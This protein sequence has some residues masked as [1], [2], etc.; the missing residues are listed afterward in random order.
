MGKNAATAHQFMTKNLSHRRVS[1]REQALYGSLDLLDG[2]HILMDVVSES[3]VLYPVRML[4]KGHVTYF[5][6]TLAK[7]MGLIAGDHP[8]IMN[9][10]LEKKLIETFSLR[11]VNEYDQSHNLKV[12]K[13]LLKPKKYMATRYL[14]LQHP[15]KTGRTSGDGRCIWNGQITHNGVVWDV[16][17]RG[18]GV[19]CL[20]PGV[21]EAG[22]PLRS[23]ST[24]FG[25]GCGLAEVDELYG[26][27]LMAES[28]HNNGIGTERV[29]CIIDLGKGLGIGVRAAP[30]LLRPAHLFLYL[31]QNRYKELKA[32]TDYHIQR[33]KTNKRWQKMKVVHINPYDQLLHKVCD[34]FA[35]FTARLDRDYIFAW[36]DWDGDNVLIDAGIID[37]GS[38]RQ[39][40]LRHDQYRYDD[41]DRFSTNLN[42]QK[43]R[44]RT[45][46][47]VFAQ[48]VDYL[49]TGRKKTLQNF[50]HHPVLK[51]FDR[52]LYDYILERFLFNLGYSS[53]IYIKLLEDHRLKVENLFRSY[54]TL[55]RVKTHKKTARVADGVNRPAILNMR[56]ANRFCAEE[57]VRVWPDLY[58]STVPA[59]EMFRS[60]LAQN[61]SKVDHRPGLKVI[62]EL[63]HFQKLYK[64][65]L[66]AACAYG[67]PDTI[68]RDL[69]CQAR[70]RNR[71]DRVTGNA[72]I[73]VVDAIMTAKKQGL[74]KEELQWCID[75]FI[76]W[77]SIT[78]DTPDIISPLTNSDRQFSAQSQRL[79]EKIFNIV[80]QFSEDI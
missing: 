22:R 61:V 37:Y 47:Q 41:V 12:P 52:R 58:G 36:L 13:K 60:V 32:V 73:Y 71:T 8:H 76:K 44:A 19:T 62:R 42:E 49:K 69:L 6:Y 27:A 16:S 15:D 17:S 3:C 7:E 1:D 21:V 23:G 75:Q 51:E 68:V 9:K 72:L 45:T 77:Q 74:K 33:Q 65:L 40:G 64:K 43:Q 24:D 2:S 14:Q 50:T 28:F 80:E 29:L 70:Y 30:N 5:N 66:E 35:R 63:N 57:I 31:K 53:D 67:D 55:E 4:Q 59:E 54:S 38:I 34:D 79:C 56:L 46:I 10:A 25:Y 48:L 18:T 20:A 11:I 78:A 26:C 39:F